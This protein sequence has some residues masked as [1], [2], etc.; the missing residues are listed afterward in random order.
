MGI[1]NRL[2][3]HLSNMI[4][5]GEVVERPMGIVKELVEN[6]IDAKAET[7]DIQIGQGGIESIVVIDDGCGMDAQ[8]ATLAFERSMEYPDDGISR[9]G[10]AL[11]CVRI[12]CDLTNE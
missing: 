9:G 8:D 1:I 4:A 7:I 3:A 12:S 10:A 11:Y 6:C 5:A 2:D